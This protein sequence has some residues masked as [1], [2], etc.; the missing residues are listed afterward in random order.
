MEYRKRKIPACVKNCVWDKFIGICA[1]TGTCF[2]CSTEPITRGNF[3]CGHVLSEATGGTATVDN[4]RPICPNCNSSMGTR[5]MEEFMQ[6]HGLQKRTNWNGIEFDSAPISDLVTFNYES[7][8]PHSFE[9]GTLSSIPLRK[10]DILHT[11]FSQISSTRELHEIVSI[12]HKY[13][14]LHKEDAYVFMIYRD[15]IKRNI[16]NKN[17]KTDGAPYFIVALWK[18]IFRS[19]KKTKDTDK[20]SEATESR[21]KSSRGAEVAEPTRQ[22]RKG[23]SKI[24][25]VEV[26]SEISRKEKE[27]EEKK[28]KYGTN[29]DPRRCEFIKKNNERCKCF[30]QTGEKYCCTHLMTTGGP[31]KNVKRQCAFIKKNGERCKLFRKADSEFCARHV[32][33]T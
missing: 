1:G 3:H 33:K 31:T 28:K 22:K 16:E 14:L 4:L 19:R 27:E 11:V 8:V 26:S 6:E 25:V 13:K 20:Q 9:D 30:K 23:K 15:I 12:L 24:K 29:E 2:C 18:T 17:I 10:L 7:I 21:K 32:N 5:N